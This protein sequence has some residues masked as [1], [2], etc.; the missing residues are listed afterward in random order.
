MFGD[1]VQVWFCLQV[2]A[3]DNRLQLS[4]GYTCPLSLNTP[5]DKE[6]S[7][8]WCWR[9]LVLHGHVGQYCVRSVSGVVQVAIRWVNQGGKDSH[10]GFANE[11]PAHVGR[12]SQREGTVDG[13]DALTT[14]CKY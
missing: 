7:A 8:T 11:A 13:E 10:V 4:N 12:S 3:E 6:S 5:N 2:R 1:P 9:L 14:S